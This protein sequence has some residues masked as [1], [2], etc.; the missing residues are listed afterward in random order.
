MSAKQSLQIKDSENPVFDIYKQLTQ[1]RSESCKRGFLTCLLAVADP[2][3]KNNT[4]YSMGTPEADAHHFASRW[5]FQLTLPYR[6]C[7]EY[8][9]FAHYETI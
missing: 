7:P 3:L 9:A 8:F 1:G 6:D 2:S 4:P 5:A